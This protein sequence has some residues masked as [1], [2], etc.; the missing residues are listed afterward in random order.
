MNECLTIKL[1]ES[2]TANNLTRLGALKLNIGLVDSRTVILQIY[3][4]TEQIIRVNRGYFTGT[5]SQEY[6]APV[7]WINTSIEA[8]SGITEIEF[9]NKFGISRLNSMNGTNPMWAV[10][11][12]NFEI[13]VDFEDFKYCTSLESIFFSL[14][15]GGGDLEN[16]KKVPMKNIIISPDGPNMIVEGDISGILS[17]TNLENIVLTNQSQVTGNFSSFIGKTVL[18]NIFELSGTS[19][20]GSINDLNG[21]STP[22]LLLKG[23]RKFIGGDIG[24]LHNG[25]RFFS[26]AN[27]Q[28]NA[29]TFSDFNSRT[30]FLAVEGAFLKSGVNDLI[31][32]SKNLNFSST[33]SEPYERAIN[34]WANDFFKDSNVSNA[35]SILNSHGITVIVNGNTILP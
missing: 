9:S 1:K 33:G 8:N 12:N 2:S 11:T 28:N 35:I 31:I 30:N 20:T 7:G 24:T 23:M 34:I 3:S 18:A 26:V 4:H 14:G 15:K 21:V 6:N 13:Y 5:T 19:V 22:Y 17:Q 27:S 10:G 29:F 32:A 25:V 16:F